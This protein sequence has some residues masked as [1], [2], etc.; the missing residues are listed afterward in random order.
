M[1]DIHA[2]MLQVPA[3]GRYIVSGGI[4]LY[5]PNR[6]GRHAY[7]YVVP[8]HPLDQRSTPFNG[9]SIV[10]IQD[11]SENGIKRMKEFESTLKVP[12]GPDRNVEKLGKYFSS[13]C[14]SLIYGYS[15]LFKLL[16]NDLIFAR[17][18]EGTQN[19]LDDVLTAFVGD[20]YVPSN[21]I[22]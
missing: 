9:R 20:G 17:E 16:E 7:L 3:D 11:T 4:L 1:A 15:G 19:P 14:K 22:K 5:H 8:N 18:L 6:D 2:Q 10:F 12:L 13:F 21:L